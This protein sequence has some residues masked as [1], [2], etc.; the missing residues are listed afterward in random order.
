MSK[1]V[2][3][4][5][6]KKLGDNLILDDICL[7]LSSGQVIGFQ[8]INGSGKTM[9][10]RVIAG[11]VLPSSGKVLIDGK[12]LHKEIRFP[13]SMGILLES[14]SFLDM[15][16]GK[17]NLQL[18]SSLGPVIPE[19]EIDDLLREVGLFESKN[20]KYKKYSLGM[21]QRLGIAAA[22]MGNPDIILLDEPTNALD[23]NGV[24]LVRELILK[25]RERGALIVVSCHDRDF[26]DDV[27]DVIYHIQEGR[28]RDE[29]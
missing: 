19:Q 1:I 22:I 3:D 14:P 9:L 2:L 11:L 5:I 15:Y 12:E 7:S 18:L 6:S 29:A 26:L 20:R 27:S 8:G 23:T 4:H 25:Q 17:K 10:M 13:Q 24:S 28:I 21:K 16:T